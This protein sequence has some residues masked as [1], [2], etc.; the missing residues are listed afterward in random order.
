MTSV[1]TYQPARYV[2][3]GIGATCVHYAVLNVCIHL[4]HMSSAGVAN[5]LAAIMGVT[6]SFFGNRHFVF[7]GTTESIWHQ[8][9][10]FWMLYVI[11]AAMQGAVMFA[12]SD[13][14]GLDY[15]VGFLLGTFFQMICSYFGG[16]HWVF[17]R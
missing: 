6:V 4:A 15:R 1:L 8:L 17:K 10:R 7:P 14:A 2:I 11:L 16:K 13:V 5:F 9:G 12:W 3:N